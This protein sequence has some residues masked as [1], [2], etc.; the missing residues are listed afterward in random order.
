MKR[1]QW[2]S[3]SNRI[4]DFFS[5]S[6]SNSMNSPKCKQ[7]PKK[8]KKREAN[9]IFFCPNLM[10]NACFIILN[11]LFYSCFVSHSRVFNE[12]IHWFTTH[13]SYAFIRKRRKKKHTALLI[14][15][16]SSEYFSGD[17]SKPRRKW[18][19]LPFFLLSFCR[20][21]FKLFEIECYIFAVVHRSKKR[22]RERAENDGF[23]M[24]SQKMLSFWCE[25]NIKTMLNFFF[26]S[27]ILFL[28]YFVV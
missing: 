27:N 15:P 13:S 14:H 28:C 3:D 26:S 18:N 11:I 5:L 23:W 24:H 16:S 25:F 9:S 21:W 8:R 1:I 10:S 2:A 7:N 4:S 12:I 17:A 20:C 19:C 22:E 6:M